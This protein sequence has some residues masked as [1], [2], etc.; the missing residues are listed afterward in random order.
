MS[1]RG[2]CTW[3]LPTRPSPFWSL[4]FVRSEKYTKGPRKCC[5][6][7]EGERRVPGSEDLVDHVGHSG[8]KWRGSTMLILP[9]PSQWG[10]SFSRKRQICS[11]LVKQASYSLR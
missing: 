5:W 11:L 4:H 9:C 2:S 3:V 7:G 8:S 10:R 1:L 6:G